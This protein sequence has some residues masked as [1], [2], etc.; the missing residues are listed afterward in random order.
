M[1]RSLL[2]LLTSAICSADSVANLSLARAAMNRGELV[3]AEQILNTAIQ[4]AENHVVAAPWVDGPLDLLAQVYVREKRFADAAAIQ[5]RRI[6]NWTGMY[7]PNAVVVGRVLGQLA[8]VESQAGNLLAAES[9]SRRALAIMT[10]AYIDKPPSAQAAVDLADILIAENRNDEAEQMLAL[11]E[12]TFETSVGP[13]SM[14]TIAV[15]TRRATILKQLGRDAPPPAPKTT[16]YRVGGTAQNQ[17]AAPHL[18]SKVEPQ[19][20]EEAR[21]NKLQ[22]SILLSLVV[23]ATGAPTQIAVLRPLGMGLD[24]KAIEAISQWRFT[25]GQKNGSPVPVFSQ[26]EMSFHLL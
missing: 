11:A 24:E 21:Q 26:V 20:S 2:I 22:G 18:Q 4:E 12:K 8:A 3:N 6:D 23:D 13:T 25:P 19:Y 5:Q 14:L 9:R 7:G 10:A 1:K 17:V 16:V 15:T